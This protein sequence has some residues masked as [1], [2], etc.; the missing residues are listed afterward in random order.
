MS[1]QSANSYLALLSQ[2]IIGASNHPV[3]IHRRTIPPSVS[4]L[5]SSPSHPISRSTTSSSNLSRH[6]LFSF[7][8]SLQDH[9][10]YLLLKTFAMKYS[11]S[12]IILGFFTALNAGQVAITGVTYAGSGCKPGTAS[13]S[14]SQDWQTLTILF[15]E[16]E[17]YTPPLHF[18]DCNVNVQ[19]HYP[20]GHQL[21]LYKYDYTGY[22]L[23]E[24]GVTFTQKSSYWFAGFVSSKPTIQSTMYGPYNGDYTFTD[25][26]QST[27]LAWSPCGA[28]AT[29]NINTQ[30]TLSSSDPKILLLNTPPGV[31]KNQHVYGLNWRKCP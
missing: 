17:P 10:S 30:V 14:H 4:P 12:A 9:N 7:K 2:S 13:V 11:V 8:H 16:F 28:S 23:L 5:H 15:D 18:K 27:V 31:G 6:S 3:R 24:R 25:T 29:L 1:L 26:F 20:Q 19:F 21:T 22:A